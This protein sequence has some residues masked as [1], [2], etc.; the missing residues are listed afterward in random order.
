MKVNVYRRNDIGIIRLLPNY[1]KWIG[2]SII[3]FAGLFFLIAKVFIP[4]FVQ[5]HRQ[6]F[7]D[8]A[9]RI[10]LFGLLIISLARDKVEDELTLLVRLKAMGFT[11]ILVAVIVIIEPIANLI[12]TGTAINMTS[13]HLVLRMLIAYLIIFFFLKK[14]R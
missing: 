14:I 1:F 3:I 9:P 5:N 8:L 4:E 12:W 6:V 11:F 2:L 13:P 10:L 7:F